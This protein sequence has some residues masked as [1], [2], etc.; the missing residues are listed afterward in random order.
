MAKCRLATATLRRHLQSQSPTISA[1]KDPTKSLSA[2]AA[3][4]CRS[5]SAA[6][7]DDS[8]GKWLTLPPFSPTVDGTAV[9]KELT[10]DGDSIKGST[11]GSNT[12]ALKWI[13][14]CRPD[15]PRT[16][17]QKLFRLRQVLVYL[18]LVFNS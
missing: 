13:L 11:D 10:S 12:T 16:L 7:T 2:A 6:Q 3:H 8:R 15:L 9:G 14:R 17:V 18:N 1:F 5:Y 4:Q